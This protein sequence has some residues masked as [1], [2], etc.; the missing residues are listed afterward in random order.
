MTAVISYKPST[1]A[2]EMLERRRARVYRNTDEYIYFRI[3]NREGT[4]EETVVIRK[5]D[6]YTTCTCEHEHWRK[7]ENENDSCW[8]MRKGMLSY[9]WR[10]RRGKV[11]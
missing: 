7:R 1:P 8:H 10:I 4:K 2:G 5:A 11:E 6:L 9:L 3:W